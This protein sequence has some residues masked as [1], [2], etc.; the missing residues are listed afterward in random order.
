[1]MSS[2][3]RKRLD[4]D[5]DALLLSSN[6]FKRKNKKKREE[7]EAFGSIPTRCD[8]TERS[9]HSFL[10]ALKSRVIVLSKERR[11]KAKTLGLLALQ[12]SYLFR[13]FF[14]LRAARQPFRHQSSQHFLLSLFLFLVRFLSRP[15]KSSKDWFLFILV[16]GRCLASFSAEQKI[17]L[18]FP[19]LSLSLSLSFDYIYIYIREEVKEVLFKTGGGRLEESLFFSFDRRRRKFA[20]HRK[21]NWVHACSTH[22]N[23]QI[24]Q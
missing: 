24:E 21:L 4:D 7:V 20:H 1:M 5:I 8:G 12:K 3:K 2:R 11:R 16:S 10:L 23:L 15:R 13:C 18:S 17:F 19:L 22:I 14:A 9:H 6:A